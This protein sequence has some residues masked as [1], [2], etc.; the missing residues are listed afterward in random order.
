MVIWFNVAEARK[1]LLDRGIVY[2]LRPKERREGREVLS[3]GGFGKKGIVNVR[4]EK[5]N[6]TDDDLAIHL[7]NSGFA[8]V[9]DWRRAAGD[10]SFLYCV[11]LLEAS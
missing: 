10:S 4:F 1:C 11:T 8:S 5:E 7:P 3:Y 2:T 9:D 6:P